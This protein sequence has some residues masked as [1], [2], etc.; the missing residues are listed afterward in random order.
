MNATYFYRN[1]EKNRDKNDI[2]RNSREGCFPFTWTK[3]N[4]IND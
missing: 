2:S 3:L 4:W 1:K